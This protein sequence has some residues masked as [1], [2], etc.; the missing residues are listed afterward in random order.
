MSEVYNTGSPRWS[1]ATKLVVS[2]TFVA[3]VAGLVL[4][5]RNYV[6]PILLAF[7]LAFLSYPIADW[8]HKRLKTSWRVAVTLFF[9][10]FILLVIGLLTLGGIAIVEQ[11]QNLYSLVENALFKQLPA[12][13]ETVS[14]QVYT[15]GPFTLDLTH[16][17]L[18]NFNDQILNSVQPL[19]GEIGGLL[20]KLATGAASF[21]GYVAF[22]LI[23]AY[24]IT[25]E[26]GGIQSGLIHLDLPGYSYDM[27]RMGLELK[28][29]WNSFL[30]GQLVLFFLTALIY[31]IVLSILG[32]RYSVGLAFLAGFGRFLPYV[33]PAIAWTTYSLVA[34][35]QGS[36]MFGL[37][38]LGYTA[39]VLGVAVIVDTLFDNYIS[40]M[41][42]GQTLKV[43]PAA[44]L[45]AAL[46]AANLI[47]VVGV[48]LAAP[49]L[50]TLQL[51]GA[52]AVRKLFDMDPWAGM[53]YTPPAP[54]HD[55]IPEPIRRV[56]T[57][58]WKKTTV[59][60]GATWQ[61]LAGKARQ[62]MADRSS[63]SP[64]HPPEP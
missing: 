44:V 57:E 25:S 60:V 27:R 55:Y 56:A 37:P 8:I 3:I 17:N 39:I 12:L 61:N 43:H 33:G 20:T 23:I 31:S 21:M 34:F 15:I 63:R 42:L 62:S 36:T 41:F 6:G 11:A 24:F 35:F 52:Y 22:I 10:V 18:Q 29:I 14:T 9:L 54:M 50:A 1:W 2:L 7:I 64:K 47:G 53:E 30:R 40:P 5:F 51:I 26:S 58:A 59:Y 16:F 45:V 4:R 38:P 49:V 48:L 32:L 19:V 46:I 13:L 28:R